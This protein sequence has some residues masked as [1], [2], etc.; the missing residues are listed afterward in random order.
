[1]AKRSFDG[2]RLT[3]FQAFIASLAEIDPDRALAAFRTLGRAGTALAPVTQ[4]SG[5]Q[6]LALTRSEAAQL[7]VIRGLQ[8]RPELAVKA[9]RASAELKAKLDAAGGLDR[10]LA[11]VVQEGT[12]SIQFI[13]PGVAPITVNATADAGL[14]AELRGKA[15]KDPGFVRQ[16]LARKTHD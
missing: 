11:P 5:N 1:F 7:D 10:V 15:L 14:I 9:L 4:R 6:T 13:G 8:N 16:V 12:G 2:G 3:D